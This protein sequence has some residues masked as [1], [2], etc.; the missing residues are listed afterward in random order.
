[1]AKTDQNTYVEPVSTVAIATARLQQNRSYRSLLANF[2]S[3]VAPSI[4][5]ENYVVDGAAIAPPDCTLFHLANSST[6][7]L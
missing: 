6:S 7:A 1:M 3:N 2:S 4:G 5:R